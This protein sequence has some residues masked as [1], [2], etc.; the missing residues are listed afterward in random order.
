MVAGSLTDFANAVKL[1]WNVY[2]LG[3]NN[4]LSASTSRPSAIYR[5]S[6]LLCYTYLC[7]RLS[8]VRVQKDRSTKRLTASS[9]RIDRQY[10]ELGDDIKSL[11]QNLDYIQ[12]IVRNASLSWQQQALRLRHL[13][14]PAPQKEWDLSSIQEIIGDYKTTL[15]DCEKLLEEN[16][17]FRTNRGAIYNVEWNLVIRPKVI[18]LKKR[19][20]AH[21][22]KILLLLEPLELSL[23]AD[24]HRGLS[25]VHH[26]LVER[27]NVVHQ[28]VLHLQGLL[29]PDVAQAM[30]EQGQQMELPV[31]VPDY[32][33]RK[34]LASAEKL[35]PEV[36][37]PNLFPLQLAADSFLA[38]F[39]KSTRSFEAG[40]FLTD[41]TPQPVQYLNLL[42][43][44]WIVTRIQSS[45]TFAEVSQ[46]SNDSQWPGYI[47]KLHEDVYK[48]CQR[49]S[50]PSAQRVLAPE[51]QGALEENQYDIWIEEDPSTFFSPHIEKMLPSVL[52]IPL[53]RPSETLKRQ[54]TVH[55]INQNQYK[56]V[57]ILQDISSP[58]KQMPSLEIDIDLKQ[59]S[60][61][62][63]Y[64]TPSS[65]PKALEI[66]LDSGSKQVTPEFQDIKHIYRLQ[67][68]LTGYKV[69]DRYDQAMVKV[70]FVIDGH[71]ESV[72]EHGRLQLWL[73]HPFVSASPDTSAA[74]L[75]STAVEST[76][77]I[78]SHQN[79]RKPSQASRSSRDS[80]AYSSAH[81][82]TNLPQSAAAN[83]RRSNSIP[84]PLGSPTSLASTMSLN[85]RPA[86][87]SKSST[88]DILSPSFATSRSPTASSARSSTST[89]T[90]S[91]SMSR[92][93]VTTVTTINTGGS[94]RARL[95]VKPMKPMLVIYL[96]SRDPSAKLS[97]V[98]I[99]IDDATSVKRD[100]CD[101]RSS[102]SHCRISCLERTNEPLLV[103]RW[104]ADNSLASWNLA[105]LGLEQR[106]DFEY[107]W[108]KVKRVSFKFE[109]WEGKKLRSPLS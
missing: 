54:I 53:P 43:C 2:Q 65:R 36:R 62:P 92:S 95:H 19:L 25:D 82:R 74:A 109:K 64:A 58:A 80:S 14:G 66:T 73:P 35:H 107:G 45:D 39:E 33:E 101:C 83:A 105:K 21:N 94:S 103:Q 24:V 72:Q 1:A 78:S 88:C 41:R 81:S 40:R 67:H 104:N 23:L 108:E 56:L 69:Y 61:I 32:I 49:F 71:L 11:A 86:P 26:D 60:F 84:I 31:Q 50:A 97:L 99:Q 7:S 29:I 12:N 9:C 38:H 63:L 46:P 42:K 93:T 10:A 17:E 55:P 30:S 76:A 18:H 98:A 16:P 13:R 47:N 68:L 4:E 52:E 75:E 8:P 59:F 102:S 28:S 15:A 100:R 6:S 20:E 85:R 96:K 70:S 3:W 57:E 37:Q 77:Q 27:I 79:T 51:M 22:T 44:I 48:E 87:P 106:N 34:F 89:S 5:R 91:S 90:I